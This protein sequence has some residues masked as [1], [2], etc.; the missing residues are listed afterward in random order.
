M[1][2]VPV[3]A[4]KSISNAMGRSVERPSVARERSSTEGT[5][6]S[7][8]V[9]GVQLGVARAG[10]KQQGLDD[11]VVIALAPGTRSTCPSRWHG[12]LEPYLG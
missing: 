4:A 9:A 1:I 6:V 11:V 3:V 5:L 10:V 8:G 12:T 2:L 7:E